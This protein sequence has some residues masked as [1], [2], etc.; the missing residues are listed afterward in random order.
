MQTRGTGGFSQA[1]ASACAAMTMRNR[2][3]SLSRN[4]HRFH[5]GHTVEFSMPVPLVASVEGSKAKARVLNEAVGH[6]CRACLRSR[7]RWRSIL[8][9]TP[10]TQ[11]VRFVEPPEPNSAVET[12]AVQALLARAFHRKR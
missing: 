12:D 10:G 8:R 11:K 2:L 5:H 4:R 3:Q 6:P 7:A 1:V 9:M